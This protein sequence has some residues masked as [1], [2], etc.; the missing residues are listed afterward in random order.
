MPNKTQRLKGPLPA[1]KKAAKK[2]PPT[3]DVSRLQRTDGKKN[4]H[5]TKDG[6][7]YRVSVAQ[8]VSAMRARAYW[9]VFT[10]P[11]PPLLYTSYGN[12]T[13]VRCQINEIISSN[14]DHDTMIWCGYAPSSVRM[15]SVLL[16]AGAGMLTPTLFVPQAYIGLTG[17]TNPLFIRALKMSLEVS[18]LGVAAGTVAPGEVMVLSTDNALRLSYTTGA[19]QGSAAALPT[20][21]VQVLRDMIQQSNRVHVL[22]AAT[23]QTQPHTFVSVPASYT[24]Y[25]TYRNFSS[26]FTT[27]NTVATNEALLTLLSYD[28]E[29]YEITSGTYGKSAGFIGS[30]G[31]CGVQ[32]MRQFLILIK[33]TPS[34]TVR[35]RLRLGFLDGARY[36]SNTI[37][38]TFEVQPKAGSAAT[39]EFLHSSIAA[40]S[41]SPSQPD[42]GFS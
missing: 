8:G 2:K 15:M 42:V 16:N 17:N 3:M 20:G 19:T 34:A 9:N 18:C 10:N 33:A 25:N 4:R 37:G 39:E 27:T 31:P 29:D 26:S 24:E 28:D 5:L 1:A 35:W 12:Y 22:P 41:G 6:A 36:G 11:E 13:P 21:N 38:S 32:A 23:A 7:R 14:P 40:I 30:R